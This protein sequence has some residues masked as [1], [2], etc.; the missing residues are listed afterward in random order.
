MKYLKTYKL[1]ESVTELTINSSNKYLL[2]NLPNS[3]TYLN[4]CKNEL[5]SLPELPDN[6]DYLECDKNELTSLPKLPDSLTFLS[7]EYNKLTILPEL[8]D[9]IYHLD[10]ND[11]ELTSLPKLPESLTEL[12]CSYNQL[13]SLPELPDSLTDLYCWNN[14][15]IK[16]L[17]FN[18]VQKFNL[19]AYTVKQTE[20][21]NSYEFQLEHLNEF[22]FKDYSVSGLEVHEKIFNKILD[23]ILKNM[24]DNYF[25]V[26]GEK[27]TYKIDNN[28]IYLKGIDFDEKIKII[29]NLKEL[30]EK[31]YNI[32]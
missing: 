26:T 16:P 29:S 6:L 9:S 13:T 11:N 31:I 28:N 15:W 7:C 32:L 30:E 21:F 1:F 2:D 18:I 24:L 14:K 20:L 8:T 23:K 4:C 17:N 27:I 3:L 10:C 5:T 12:F 25:N 19:D 22:N